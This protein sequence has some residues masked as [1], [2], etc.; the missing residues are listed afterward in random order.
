MPI[1]HSSALPPE[2]LRVF[3]TLPQPYLILS[4]ELYILTASNAYL[5]LTGKMR[6]E[7]LEK[8][9][10]DVFP[11]KPDWAADEGGIAFSLEQ[12]LE[13]SKPHQLPVTRFDTPDHEGKLQ[14]RYW[15][16]AHT[17][18]LDP[19][20]DICY[21][22]H[23]TQDVTEKVIA[24]R[25]LN[26]SLEKEKAAAARAGQLS[27]QMEKLFDEIPAQIAIFTGPDLVYEFINPQY[28][29]EFFPGRKILGKPLLMAMPE[30]VGLP[31]WE[32]V[33]HVYKTGETYAGNEICVPL[34]SEIGGKT[35]DHYFNFIYQAIRNEK[36]D[37]TGVLSFKY[38]ITEL[39]MAKKRL[40]QTG[41]ELSALNE[42]LAHANEEIQVTSEEIQSANEELSATNEELFRTQQN[43]LKLNNELESR[44][45]LRTLELLSAQADATGQTERLK[46]F[47]MQAPAAIC[48][49]DG[50]NFV[51]ELVNPP[52][53]QL[54]PG[55]KLTG[56]PL[57]EALPELKDQLIWDILKNVYKTGNTF[58]GK[59]LLVPMAREANGP[60]E[61]RYF[62]FIYQARYDGTNKVDGIMVFVFEVTEAVLVR[63]KEKENEERFRFLLN[64]MPQ[65]VWTAR[66]N[67]KLD[68]VNEVICEDFGRSA[69][70]IIGQGW[71]TFI[72][73][74]D[75]QA[76][77]KKWLTALRTG[78]EYLVEF[79]LKFQDGQYRWH[80]ARAVPLIENG[81]I[82]LWL[83]TNTNIDI[84]KNNEQK[85][86]EFLSIASHELKTP[87]TS[88]KAFNQLMMRI[89]DP[90]KLNDLI[91]KSAAHVLR[92]EKLI[93]DLLDVSRINAGKMDYNM[94]TFNFYEMLKDTIDGVQHTTASHQIILES[95]ED[96]TYTG[97]RFRLEQVVNNLLTNAIKYSPE[98]NTIT[99]NCT[100]HEDNSLIVSVQDFGIGIEEKNLSRLFERYYRVDNTAMR[101]EGL[102]LG[103]F[104]SAEILKRHNGSFW[105]ESTPGEGSTFFFRLLTHQTQKQA[106][107]IQGDLYYHDSAI[108]LSY[109]H[110]HSRIDADWTGF[111]NLES[112]QQGCNR[113][114]NMMVKNSVYKVL[115]NNI[116]VLG[117]WSEAIDWVAQEWFPAMQKAGLRYFAW[118]NSPSV[119]N[120]LS[121]RKSVNTL[122]DKMT[123]NF[124]TDVISAEAWINEQ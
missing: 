15:D 8:H 55:R 112:I 105:I 118:V 5:Q 95:A 61:D 33:Q 27:R 124:F 83:G 35:E 115:N 85:K 77:L 20:G 4:K 32:A 88:I 67:G 120:Q 58:E 84:Q 75:Q 81:E 17:P 53:Q 13:T 92:L 80:L 38:D 60:I 123:I 64:A 26:A 98:A 94:E 2:M 10:F 16:T 63:Q 90:P 111:Q 89:N 100:L 45:E 49:L 69:D 76:C 12:I 116:H 99:V 70:D 24:E 107:I 1:K 72:H 87:L 34:T 39:V 110:V 104:I 66:P 68:Y 9:L 113:M 29:K 40:E 11:K 108:T 97:D 31:V 78:H 65:Q 52:Y 56:N 121:A 23:H 93:S 48:V 73:P 44:V 47:F 3:E 96:I 30:I 101:F 51:F 25:N 7:L 117:N 37:I 46:R 119:F 28:E 91:Q 106:A 79:R 14:E 59:E 22:I 42:G 109:N 57:L 43:L 71:Q 114:L 41:K 62:T 6:A 18:V 21:I 82:K 50:P 74:D 103:L 36:G 122:P 86:D 19:D 54:F 102:G